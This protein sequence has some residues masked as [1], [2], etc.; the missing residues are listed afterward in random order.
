MMVLQLILN[1]DPIGGRVAREGH[2]VLLSK[3]ITP[4]GQAF[5]IS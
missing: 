5:D 4:K 2:A 1:G 3:E